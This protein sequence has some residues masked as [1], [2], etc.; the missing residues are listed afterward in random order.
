M[1]TRLLT[2]T[3]VLAAF[4]AP[5]RSDDAADVLKR[6]DARVAAQLKADVAAL[7]DTIADG[8]TYTHSSSVLE[9]GKDFIDGVRTGRLKYKSYERKE[10]AV[11]LHGDTAIVTGKA[12]VVVVREGADVPLRLQFTNVWVKRAGKWRMVSWHSTRLPEN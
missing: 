8:A 11:A 3:L 1:T 4:A 5:A 6:D 12:F 2:M 10:A 9:S 7:A